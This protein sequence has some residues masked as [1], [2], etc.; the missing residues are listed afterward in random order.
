MC[1]QPMVYLKLAKNNQKMC[2]VQAIGL[3][4]T[5]ILTMYPQ[6]IPRTLMGHGC[7][8]E[9]CFEKWLALEEFQGTIFYTVWLGYFGIKTLTFTICSGWLS[10]NLF[11]THIP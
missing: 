7:P 9:L 3:G 5:G 1:Y 2:N 4:N 6:K 11:N 10:S 8:L